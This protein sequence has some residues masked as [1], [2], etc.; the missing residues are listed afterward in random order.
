MSS[1]TMITAHSGADGTPDN[2]L[3]FVRHALTLPV[4]ALEVDVRRGADGAPALGHDAAG[5]DAPRLDEVFALVQAHPSMQINCDLKEP[6]LEET[7][8]RLALSHGLGGRVVFSGT[9]DARATEQIPG[10]QDAVDIYLNLEE[11]V[12]W[13]DINIHHPELLFQA[14]RAKGALVGIAHPY[15]FGHPFARG[16]RFD[17]KVTDY[18]CVDFIEIFNNPEPLHEVNERGLQLWEDLVLSG[19]KLAMTCGMDLHGKWSMANQ[20]ATFIEGEPEGDISRELTEAIKNQKT[21]I[22]RGPVLS[23]NISEGKL[24]FTL[25][26]TGKPGYHHD[27]RL[28]YLVS[29]R[30]A[31][32]TIT[33]PLG[34]TFLMEEFD[35][36]PVLIP[37]LFEGDTS[38][39]NLICVGSALCR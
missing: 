35:Q 39:E 10:L 15:S 30:S 23:G 13:E 16:C 25:T 33:K 1:Q 12:P 14:A 18:S 22:S 28:P 29:V 4:D 2:S 34:E 38:L 36:D 27:S 8:Y 26:E 17:M 24:T 6:G 5:S 37:K 32:H 11:Y 3:V 19:E 7:V 20:Y 21:C 9:V 31:G